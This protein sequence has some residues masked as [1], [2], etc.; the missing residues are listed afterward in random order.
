MQATSDCRS[1]GGARAAGCLE[2]WKTKVVCKGLDRGPEPKQTRVLQQA[3][4]QD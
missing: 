3:P 2:Q 4:L 1:E